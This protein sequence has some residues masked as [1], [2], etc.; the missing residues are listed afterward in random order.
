MSEDRASPTPLLL[1]T[2]TAISLAALLFLGA[3]YASS[4]DLDP[5]S[6][7]APVPLA[8]GWIPTGD[9]SALQRFEM[10]SGEGPEDLH[11]DLKDRVIGGLQ[12]G[13]VVRWNTPDA[14]PQTWYDTGGRPL[15]LHMDDQ[16]RILVADAWKGLLRLTDND[17]GPPHVEVL[18]TE[19]G[20]RPLVF[21]DDLETG[22]DG[23]I[24]F[25]DASVKFNQ[26]QWKRDLLEN[27]PNGRLCVYDPETG[28]TQEVVRDLYFANGVAVDPEGRFVLVNETARYR[29]RKLWLTGPRQG[30]LETLIDNLPGFPDGISTGSGGVYWIAIAGPR[31]ALLDRLSG[32]PATRRLI[33][34]LPKVLQP[35]PER[36]TRALGVDEHGRVVHDLYDPS[37]VQL[38]VV[39]SVQEHRGQLYLGSLVDTAWARVA[40]P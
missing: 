1:R 14:S 29:V 39:T 12:D 33:D 24:W 13:R 34:G 7:D 8:E 36:S 35:A 18:T 38:T 11:V 16:G 40:R 9:F 23:R 17:P 5:E 10:D 3:A 2:A 28:K 4:D 20:G 30:E 37:G 19:C 6:W 22:P 32:Y 27:R 26:A 31:N 21:T 25:S 15:G